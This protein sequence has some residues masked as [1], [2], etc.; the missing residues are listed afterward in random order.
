MVQRPPLVASVVLSLVATLAQARP[1]LPSVVRDTRCLIQD[2]GADEGK[3]DNL[4]EIRAAISACAGGGTV[5][6]EGGH[7][8]TSPIKVHNAVN[9]LIEVQADASLVTAPGPDEWPTDD[10]G[11]VPFILFKNTTGCSLGGDGVVWGRGGRPDGGG[12]DWYYKFD[13][14]KVDDVH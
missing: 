14:G 1:Y 2:H 8:K 7:Y 3:D 4:K 12:S 10:D 13:Q 11:M 6:V 9:L 5:V